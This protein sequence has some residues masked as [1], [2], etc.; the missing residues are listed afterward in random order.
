MKVLLDHNVPPELR[1]D[2][3]ADFDVETA[4]YREW[5]G[6][7]DEALLDAAEDVFAVLV[8]LDTSIPEQQNTE[9][10]RIGV[11]VLDVHPI[12]P[13]ELRKH[14]PSV[15]HAVRVAARDH[16]VVRVTEESIYFGGEGRR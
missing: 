15:N 12:Y 5:E 8:T 16:S 1:A 10:L 6:L 4:E 9:Q 14:V 7:D 3:A 11:V 13:D 2:F